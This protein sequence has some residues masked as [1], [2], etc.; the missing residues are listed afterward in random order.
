MI[1]YGDPLVGCDDWR[2]L[3]TCAMTEQPLSKP[4]S[5]STTRRHSCIDPTETV[6]AVSEQPSRPDSAKSRRHSTLPVPIPIETPEPRVTTFPNQSNRSQR[7]KCRASCASSSQFPAFSLLFHFAQQWPERLA[8]A[9]NQKHPLQLP[10]A[11]LVQ[12]AHVANEIY[13]AAG[14]L[15]RLV[16]G[17]RLPLRPAMLVRSVSQ[18]GTAFDMHF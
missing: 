18:H 13:S 9:S 4:P 12:I 14:S 11:E 5:A 7:L 10:T 17:Q 16:R 3:G 15:P 8:L 6:K 2:Q 1:G